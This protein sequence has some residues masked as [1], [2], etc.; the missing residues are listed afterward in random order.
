MQN[1][2]DGTVHPALNTDVDGLIY[3]NDREK[4]TLLAEDNPFDLY[5]R[6]YEGSS[7]KGY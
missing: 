5:V 3:D 2:L 4:F 7:N 6:R 1:R